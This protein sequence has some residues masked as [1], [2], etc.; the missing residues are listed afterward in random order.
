M[1]LKLACVMEQVLYT[2]VTLPNE[3]HSIP[4]D[5]AGA[6]NA[7]GRKVAETTESSGD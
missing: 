4:D 2:R 5:R 7:D 3:T 6:A 1:V